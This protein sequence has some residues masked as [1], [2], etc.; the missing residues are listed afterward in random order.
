ML[1][2]SLNGTCTEHFGIG[3]PSLYCFT[4]T[5]FIWYCILQCL[6]SVSKDVMEILIQDIIETSNKTF[7]LAK[8][9]KNV[10]LE[11]TEQCISQLGDSEEKFGKIL[12]VRVCHILTQ[13]AMNIEQ[14]QTQI[15]ILAKLIKKM[16]V[17]LIQFQKGD[18]LENVF[19]KKMD[20]IEFN[21]R[22]SDFVS[23]TEGKKLPTMRNSTNNSASVEK[24]VT[25]SS[26]ESIETILCLVSCIYHVITTEWKSLLTW[27]FNDLGLEV[28]KEISDT[29]C[30][31]ML[32]SLFTACKTLQTLSVMDKV[33]A[34]SYKL[35]FLTNVLEPY[36]QQHLT[37][38]DTPYVEGI[39]SGQYIGD[40]WKDGIGKICFY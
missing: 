4:N 36:F 37:S 2:L 14:Q 8:D 10:V 34:S 39:A 26:Q 22:L 6:S 18:N 23:D 16:N 3:P 40:E 20:V 28:V 21:E 24:V 27:Q 30:H 38:E 5:V 9:D 7:K 19:S 11:L 1:F 15:D 29:Q 32:F 12:D 17:L 13:F 33:L 35:Q 25:N 31:T